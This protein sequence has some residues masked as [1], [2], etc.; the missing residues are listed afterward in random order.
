MTM[1]REYSI[2]EIEA[3]RM[4]AVFANIDAEIG[5]WNA[6]EETALWLR[7]QRERRHRMNRLHEGVRADRRAKRAAERDPQ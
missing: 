1:A 3:D 6:L 7:R 5:E 4:A 2:E